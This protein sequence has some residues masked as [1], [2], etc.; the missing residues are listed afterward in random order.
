M[1]IKKENTDLT[2]SISV[3]II[4][5]FVFIFLFLF[6]GIN[7]RKEDFNDAK[8]LAVEISRKAAFETQS[9]LSS[10]III[11][12]S[13]EQRTQLL[14]KLK[15]SKKEINDMLKSAIVNNPNFLGVW[16]LWEPNAFDCKDNMYINDS[17]YNNQD[18]SGIGY[19]RYNNKI[20]T[21]VMTSAEYMEPYYL[22]PKEL[23]DEV[24]IEPYEF[25][26]IGHDQLFFGT[27]ISVPVIVNDKFW[28]ALG[29]DIDLV[30][31]QKELSKVRPYETGYLSLISNN[32]TIVTHI[33]SSL[34]NKNIFNLLRSSDT[35]CC[36]SIKNGTELTLE[37]KSEF[38]GEKVFRLFYPIVI[39]KGSMPWSMMVEIPIEKTTTSS[40]QLFIIAIIT[41]VIGFSLLFYLV[42]NI[43]ERKRYEKTIL[44]AK[45]EAEESNRLKTAFLNNISHEIRTPLNGIIGF[46]EL[47][48]ENNVTDEQKKVYKSIIHNSSNQ[49]LSIISNVLELSKI[50]S[51]K[52][53]KIIREFD[54]ESAISKVVAF[55]NSSA[56]EKGIQIITNYPESEQKTRI[57]SDEDKFKQILSYLVNNAIKFT[58]SGF[59]EVGFY[60]QQESV[61]FYVMDTGIGIKPESANKIFKFFNQENKSMTR[62]FGGLGIGLSISKSFIDLLGGKIQFESEPENPAAGKA[63]GTTFYFTLPNT[64]QKSKPTDIQNIFPPADFTILIAEDEK[65]NYILLNEIINNSGIKTLWASNGEEAVNLCKSNPD[66]K[67]VLMDIKMPVMNGYEAC[68][69]IKSFKNNLPVIAVTANFKPQDISQETT[70]DSIISKPFKKEELMEIITSVINDEIKK[71]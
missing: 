28:G 53:E 62:Y 36:N 1:C 34:V 58:K 30:N 60:N 9:Y 61:L 45:F 10:A 66:I 29:I 64:Q 41:L 24:I 47:L 55:Y 4:T 46:T 7:H 25:Y 67:L 31:L 16:T 23:K 48:T 59:V 33:D 17:L 52:I 44:A 50:Q 51:M 15:G 6:L 37:T 40:K 14:H 39:S 2:V 68:K 19:F 27:T 20:Y 43:F 57:S 22:S 12:R 18:A 49:L 3:T 70:F 21:E 65:H 54:V 56:D 71:A 63:G 8:K 32:G 35:L 42:Y 5:A 13:L 11:A 69:I 38:T 26:Y